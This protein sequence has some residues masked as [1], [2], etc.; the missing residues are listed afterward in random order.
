MKADFKRKTKIQ[1]K[2]K[3]EAQVKKTYD[4]ISPMTWISSRVVA[5]KS[6]PNIND[7]VGKHPVR[8]TQ[9]TKDIHLGKRRLQL[10]TP[11]ILSD[12]EQ[13]ALLFES[14]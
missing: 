13:R 4:K 12:L 9:W 2:K 1:S 7:W 14:F 3:K 5:N 10:G 11:L 6:K 8:V